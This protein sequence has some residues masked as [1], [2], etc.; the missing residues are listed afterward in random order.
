MAKIDEKFIRNL[1]NFSIAL[2]NIVEI[3]KEQSKVNP[4]DVVN[5]LAENLDAENI[6]KISQDLEEVK[7]KSVYIADNTDKILKEVK[8]I[9]KAT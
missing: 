3:L 5:Q 9:N 2:E 6:Q 4:T 1:N 7:E 8:T